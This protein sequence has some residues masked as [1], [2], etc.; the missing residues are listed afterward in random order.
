[1][2]DIPGI[3]SSNRDILFGLQ[4]HG[5]MAY[6]GTWKLSKYRNGVRT[7]FKMDDDKN[8]AKNLY[9]N[10]ENFVL[11]SELEAKLSTEIM[12]S[13]NFSVI[14]RM[15]DTKNSLNE[16]DDFGKEGWEWTYPAS[17]MRKFGI[18]SASDPSEV[19]TKKQD[20]G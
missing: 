13:I 3:D 11:R 20:K 12:D 17:P 14:D 2:P 16:S 18:T 5:W 10:P 15:I 6:D 7:L 8:E 4:P 19:N 1:M 9:D